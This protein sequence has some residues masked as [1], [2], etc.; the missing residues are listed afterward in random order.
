MKGFMSGD[1]AVKMI[2]DG[3]TVG[4]CG[5]TGLSMPEEIMIALEKRFQSESHPN[6]LTMLTCAG[7]GDKG[8]R[9]ADHL[10]HEGLVNRIIASHVGLSP[11]LSQLIVENKTQGFIVP[12]GVIVNLLRATASGKPGVITRIGLD[13]YADPRLEGCK[14]NAITTEDIVSLLNMNGKEWL[15]YK[16]FPLD[17]A[18][19]TA[20]TADTHGNL[21]LE[22]EAVI[23][24]QVSMA[25]AAKNSGGIVIAQVERIVAH[26][27]LNPKDV[28]I[29]GI[30]VDYVV[31]AQPEN[32]QQAFMDGKYCP[33]FSGELRVPKQK[34]PIM[35]LN[36]RKICARRAVKEFSQGSVVILGVGFPESVANVLAEEGLEDTVT[37]T[38][39]SGTISGM[40]AGG[41]NFGASTNPDCILDMTY[42]VDFLDGGGVDIACLGLAE[43]D[44][45]GNLNVSKFGG[46]IVGSGGFID[47]AQ[48]SKTVIFCGTFT[49]GGLKT[50]VQNGNVV[51]LNEGRKKKFV[52]SVEQITFSGKYAVSTGQKVLFITERAVFALR[53]E[54]MTLI[55]IAPGID[56]KKDILNHMDFT[57]AIAPDLKTMDSSLF[58]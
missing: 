8:S 56:L 19:I 15:F 33:A 5:F 45:Q 30:M 14:S 3:A 51:I 10:A 32:H 21:T 11:H 31:V 1:E 2:H 55:E 9:G 28:R 52:K 57:P 58:K 50:A 26:G 48:N 42:Q 37:L 13:T 47:I 12:L 40:M 18:V 44:A 53:K 34:L 41:L 6:N 43:V 29:P 36:E 24:E 46:R 17:I 23:A 25:Q 20:T 38:T 7:F 27:S 35:P 49:A 22:K 54:G 16:S 39:D 4:I